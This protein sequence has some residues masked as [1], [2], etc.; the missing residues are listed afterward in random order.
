MAY[1]MGGEAHSTTNP[2]VWCSHSEHH[3]RVTLSLS[4]L[5]S[6][7]EELHSCQTEWQPD[8]QSCIGAHVHTHADSYCLCQ[9]Q[10][11]LE[12]KTSSAFD[13]L[14]TEM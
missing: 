7:F 9:E 14:G 4:I 5:S 12:G 1:K 3:N 8:T 6:L 2:S 11:W 10:T 13:F